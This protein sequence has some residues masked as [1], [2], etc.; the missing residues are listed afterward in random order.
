MKIHQ[1]PDAA[2]CQV[3]VSSTAITL[4][5]LIRAAGSNKYEIPNGANAAYIQVDGESVRYLLDGNTPTASLGFLANTYDE[6]NLEGVD[7]SQVLFIR[8]TG[9]DATMHV[10]V[11]T[12]HNGEF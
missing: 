1:L 12:I 2:S 9:S 6:I 11:A 4:Q 5:D 3:T 7:L 10:Q 8:A